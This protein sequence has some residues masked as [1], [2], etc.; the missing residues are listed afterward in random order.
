M[1]GTPGTHVDAGAV[2]RIN[3]ASSS[4]I[5]AVERLRDPLA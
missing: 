5:I 1:A 3:A 2:G 4:A